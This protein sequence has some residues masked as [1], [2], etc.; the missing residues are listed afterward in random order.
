MSG[1]PTG[2]GA[3]EGAGR[4]TA[5]LCE[6]AAWLAWLEVRED[7]A[8]ASFDAVR[9]PCSGTVETGFLLRLLEYG[10]RGVIVLGCPK[11][12]CEYTR[13]SHR[14]EK[15]VGVARAALREAGLNEERIRMDF[16][17]SVD[18]P[19]L[20]AV[21]RAFIE[22]LDRGAARADSAPGAGAGGSP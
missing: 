17:S 16:I 13:G 7:P 6:N 12:S 2:R 19:R 21:L 9:L 10:R 11:D 22:G 5:L 20:I 4:A 18:G 14:A 8:V 15:R 3:A 1:T